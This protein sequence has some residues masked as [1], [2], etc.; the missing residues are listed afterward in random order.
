MVGGGGGFLGSGRDFLVFPADAADGDFAEGSTFG[1]VASA[2]LAKVTRLRKG[3]VV[4]V[5]ELGVGGVAS[6]AMCR[7]AMVQVWSVVLL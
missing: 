3:V 4:V 7:R 5:T 1:P 2:G 6:R